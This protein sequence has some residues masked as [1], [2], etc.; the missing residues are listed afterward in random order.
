MVMSTIRQD[1]APEV[2]TGDVLARFQERLGYV[3]KNPA[4][5]EQALTHSSYVNEANGELLQHNERLEFLGDAILDSIIAE[6]LYRK[7]PE[8]REGVLTQKRAAIV[9]TR[10]LMNIVREL[11]LAGCLR[12][13]RGE[14]KTGGRQKASILTDTVEALVAAIYLDAGIRK[15]RQIVL[16]LCRDELKRHL[17]KDEL[18]DPMSRLQELVQMRGQPLPKYRM[19]TELG[20]CHARVFRMAVYVEGEPWGT[21]EGLTKKAAKRAAARDALRRIEQHQGRAAWERP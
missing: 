3:F 9:S 4:L 16:R 20:P 12:L 11:D 10:G 19:L 8:D 7:F 1:Q 17:E 13:G 6:Y 14:E 21:G 18:L 15:T 5:L 2:R